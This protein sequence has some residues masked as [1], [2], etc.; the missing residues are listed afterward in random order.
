MMTTYPWSA[1]RM[2]GQPAET[3]G[4]ASAPWSFEPYVQA[5]ID[6]EGERMLTAPEGIRNDTLNTAAFNLGQLCPE[7]IPEAWLRS[8]LQAW[9]TTA[10][11][12]SAETVKTTSSGLRA[13]MAK[14]RTVPLLPEPD[15]EV[16]TDLHASAVARELAKLRI[17]AE[18][19]S[20]LALESRP[21]KQ[22]VRVATAAEVLAD[23]PSPAARVTDLIGWAASTLITAQ[24]K[25]GKTT[26]MLNLS[27]SLLLG[28]PFLGRFPVRKVEGRVALLNF[29]VSAQ[30]LARWALEADLPLDRIITVNLRGGANP[31]TW[32][33]DRAELAAKLRE[34]STETLLTDPFSRAFT[35]TDQN[36]AADVSSFL[37]MLDQ[38]CRSEVGALDLVLAAHAG[39][40]GE[41]TR[42]SSA[43][44]DWPDTIITMTKDEDDGQRY[45]RAMGRDVDLEEDQLSYVEASRALTLAGVGSRIQAKAVQKDLECEAEILAALDGVDGVG[46]NA[47]TRLLSDLGIKVRRED[48]LRAVNRLIGKGLIYEELGRNRAKILHRTGGSGLP[49]TTRNQ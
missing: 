48:Q 13:G 40:S 10:G 2:S 43:L 18:A 14:P 3:N 11:L 27:R 9:A 35:G 16:I 39:W 49:G 29:E 7:Y 31:L 34:R 19:K 38:F 5:A 46:R 37:A 26:L 1:R 12:T 4:R 28:V 32:A 33:E 21:P 22:P 6:Q 44:E 42:G 41:R 17:S 15:V 36:S 47:L 24:R 8:Q 45:L 23:P 20:L 25:T 30:Q